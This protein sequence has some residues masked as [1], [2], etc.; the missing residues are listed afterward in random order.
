VFI[1]ENITHLNWNPALH[2]QLNC[3]SKCLRI[4]TQIRKSGKAHLHM[5]STY[6]RSFSSSRPGSR[7]H[8]RI[9]QHRNSELMRGATH[10]FVAPL[11]VLIF[12]WNHI[13]SRSFGLQSV[14][15][16]R[17]YLTAQNNNILHR[18]QCNYFGQF[19]GL[20]RTIGGSFDSI[21]DFILLISNM[22]LF[23][24][25]SVHFDIVLNFEIEL[26]KPI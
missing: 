11:P 4:R 1:I 21:F 12:F 8:A 9:I 24:P 2:F 19:L 16:S 10:A 14:C 26:T 13:Q 18:D 7:P 3:I 25:I 20:P 15:H 23:S 17:D 5:C 22:E 6:L